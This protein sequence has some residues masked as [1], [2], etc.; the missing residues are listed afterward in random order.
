[1][2]VQCDQTRRET[3]QGQRHDPRCRGV[4]DPQP[5]A[6]ARSHVQIGIGPA[7]DRDRVAHPPV[8]RGGMKIVP[9]VL[10]NR[11]VR[12][13]QPV[14]Q[15][16]RQFACRGPRLA[17]P[18]FPVFHDQGTGQPARYLFKTPVVG[19]IP[20]GTGIGGHEVIVERLARRHRSLRQRC[21]PIHRIFYAD[22]V[23]VN[24]GRLRQ[25]VD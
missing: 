12:I 6:L 13:E 14:I 10:D 21:R 1:M 11:G 22:P 2:S 18:R 23:P 15:N 24:G 8:M 19:V 20:V 4:D 17:E 25:I 9:A 7:V 16:Q 5:N 3:R